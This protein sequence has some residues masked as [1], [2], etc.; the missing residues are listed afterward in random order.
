MVNKQT[1][2]PTLPRFSDMVTKLT[3]PVSALGRSSLLEKIPSVFDN[4]AH[5]LFVVLDNDYAEKMSKTLKHLEQNDIANCNFDSN[6]RKETNATNSIY[7]PKPTST[8]HSLR[9]PFRKITAILKDYCLNSSLAG[10]KYIADDRYHPGERLFWLICVLASSF[11]SYYLISEY[12]YEFESGAMSIVDEGLD[13]SMTSINLPSVAICEIGY[14]RQLYPKLTEIVDNLIGNSSS[15]EQNDIEEFLIRLIFQNQYSAGSLSPY[16]SICDDCVQCPTKD[17]QK[18]AD[19]VRLS[20]KDL[21]VSCIWNDKEFDCCKYFLPMKTT[22]GGCFMINSIQ[23]TTRDSDNWLPMKVDAGLP[24]LKLKIRNAFSA[25]I[26]N[27]EDIPHI[28]PMA[29]EFSLQEP[30]SHDFISLRLQHMHNDVEVRTISPDYRRCIFP[31]EKHFDGPFK[32]YSYSVCVAECQ[33]DAQIRYC[34]CTHHNLHYECKW[35]DSKEVEPYS[36]TF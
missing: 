1:C 13:R 16:C 27:K 22:E 12:H 7:R 4:V 26:I 31:W 33:R 24:K 34:N 25:F 28:I 14:S 6:Y 17:Y 5:S 19:M 35:K 20:C 23:K 9:K 10:V 3:Q 8:M 29:W 2:E 15:E 21:F 30:G 11:G 36:F 32:L 18:Y